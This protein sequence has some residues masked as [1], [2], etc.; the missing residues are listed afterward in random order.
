VVP[1]ILGVVKLVPVHIDEPPIEVLYQLIVPALAVAPRS[2]VPE[3]QT[4]PGIVPEMV[5]MG[6]IDAITGVRLE[7]VHPLAVA[8]T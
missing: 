4:E 7:V 6:L 5:G 2:T 3:P 1:D 8:S